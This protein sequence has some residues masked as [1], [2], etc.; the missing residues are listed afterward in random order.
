MMSH[1]ET[2]DQLDQT[3]I[4][5]I[6]IAGRFPK[7]H[8]IDQFWQNLCAGMEAITFFSDQEL[9]AA[10]VD[11]ATLQHPNYVKAGVMLDDIELF[12]AAFFGFSHREAQII[13]PQQR[14]FLECSW[15]ALEDAGYNPELYSGRIGVYAGVSMNTYLL[16]C[17]Y[18]NRDLIRSLGNLQMIIGNDKDY[19]TARVSYKLNLKGPSV[20]VQTA[21]ST[22]LVAVHLACQSLL[23]SECDMALAGGVAI[24]IP[25]RVGYWYQEGGIFSPDGHCRTFDARSQGTV[26]GS[27]VGVVVLKRLEDAIADGDSIYA[28][29]KGSAINND[30]S[31]KVGFT[32]PSIEGQSDVIAEAIALASV[33]PET[34]TYVEAHGTSTPIGDPIEVAAL[35]RVFRSRTGKPSFCAIGSVKTN[36]GHLDTAAGIAG[37]IKTV[38]ALHHKQLPP[39]LHFEQPNPQINFTNSPF[40][41]NTQLAEWK[42]GRSPRRAGVSSFGIGGTNAHVVLEEVALVETPLP[43]RPW[44]L[45]VLSAK[46]DSALDAAIGNLVAYLKHHPDENLADVAYTLQVGRC[47]FDRRCMLVC[48]DRHDALAALEA[49]DPERVLTRIPDLTEPPVAFM[50][51]GQGTQYPHMA[52]DLYQSEPTFQAQVDRCAALLRP[53]LGIDLRELLY[54]HA[55]QAEPAEYDLTQTWLAQPALFVVEYALACTYMA[56]GVRPQAMIGHSIGEYVAACLAGVLSLN[57]ALALV[58]LRGRIVQQVQG[59][60]M[61]SVALPEDEVRSL[62]GEQLS[63]AAVNAPSLCV[64]AGP[65]GAVESFHQQLI[66]RQVACR[67]LHTSHA[68]HSAMMDQI[69]Q[70]FT[71][72]VARVDLRAPSIPYLSNV[73]GTWITA[74]DATNP[75]YWATHLRQTVRFAGGVDTLLQSPGMILLEVGPGQTLSTLVRQQGDARAGMVLSSLCHSRQLQSEVALPLA[76]LGKLWLAGV[77]IDWPA[78]YAHE[79]R[80]RL[81]LPTYPFERRRYWIDPP[82]QAGR[83]D[84]LYAASVYTPAASDTSTDQPYALHPQPS[85]L[86]PYVAPTTEIEQLIADLWKELLGATQPGIHDNFFEL[87]GH[88]LLATQLIARLREIFLVDLP[89]EVLFET[90]TIVRLAEVVEEL[91]TE[92]VE[93]LA[94][95]ELQ[96]LL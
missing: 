23:H 48:R 90:P 58:A 9:Q 69:V 34:I 38:L 96:H 78:M 18:P 22:S 51:P 41:V 88:S 10:G 2:V 54:P 85:R 50:F 33:D 52:Q 6:G 94:D 4:A 42:T 68:F 62:L 11:T 3:A 59:G 40:Y 46:T 83:T 28:I 1:L 30:G 92:K 66:A 53:H 75:S 86:T 95:E 63:L 29:I 80:R 89:L 19:L 35:N 72:Q 15:E 37:L 79:R 47:A 27:G 25:Q 8:N 71:E 61:L 56:W 26:A 49:R 24:R 31:T 70:V 44:H 7:A 91:L 73:T 77:A 65:H 12:D 45:L 74:Q 81:H 20:N 87:G 93:A 16:H 64:V 57:D 43:S 55:S 32:A 67:P 13:D 14:F 5:I 17:L 84:P 60:A 39:S 36:I 21:C 76:T 82:T